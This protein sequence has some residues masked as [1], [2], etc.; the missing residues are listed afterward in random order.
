VSYS[1]GPP[2][3]TR[4]RALTAPL[5][6]C[7]GD[8]EAR[9]VLAGDLRAAAA[10]PTQQTLKARAK[11]WHNPVQI[12]GNPFGVS[13]GPSTIVSQGFT[14][15]SGSFGDTTFTQFDPSQNQQPN[16]F[17]EDDLK[18]TTTP[19]GV[20][21]GAGANLF[22]V[23]LN[24]LG[25]DPSG[26]YRSRH[27]SSSDGA[28]SPALNFGIDIPLPASLSSTGTGSASAPVRHSSSKTRKLNNASASP[29]LPLAP[30]GSGPAAFAGAAGA[31]RAPAEG[32][33]LPA[34]AVGHTGTASYSL[35][36]DAELAQ[37]GEDGDGP[38]SELAD[39]EF[40]PP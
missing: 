27:D 8:D 6:H 14:P 36:E 31:F 17:T 23:D 32:K 30:I 3:S 15:A 19:A 37:D 39:G 22:G 35:S 13:S 38:V 33:V 18:F 21:A 25:F 10:D 12:G 24:A 16:F 29:A 11:S 1:P 2:A 40:Q 20:G 5:R 4:G 9:E 34:N 28:P 7:A 26:S